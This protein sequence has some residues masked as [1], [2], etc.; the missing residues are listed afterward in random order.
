MTTK[1]TMNGTTLQRSGPAAEPQAAYTHRG[2]NSSVSR[3]LGLSASA[4]FLACSAALFAQQTRDPLSVP[5]HQWAVD[6]ANNEIK[7]IEYGDSYLR[8]RIHTQDS[9]GDQVRDVI[10]SKDGAVARLI[11]KENRP[12]TPEE[13]SD[14]RSRLQAMLDSPANFAKHISRDNNGKKTAIDLIR[15]MP[16]AMTFTYVPGQPQRQRP[17]IKPDAPLEVVIDFQPNP[18]WK[19]P[20]ITS[21][22]LTGLKGRLWIDPQ[23]HYMTR[24]EGSIFQA[25]NVGFGLFAHVYP[26]G[27]LTFEQLEVAHERWIF[28]RF[29]ERLSVRALMLKTFKENMDIEG[30]NYSVVARMSYQDAIHMLMSTPLPAH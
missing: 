8:Y 24:M 17:H 18:A 23:T 22:A 15:M 27:Q 16:D 12:L 28:S 20:T 26:G 1:E 2:R 29:V 14:E 13:D 5:P 21:E 3:L 7:V 30:S 4:I 25:V 19:P 10:E 6:A 9:K 11:Y